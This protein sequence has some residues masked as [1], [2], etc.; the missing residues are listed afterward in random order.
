MILLQIKVCNFILLKEQ[1]IN[2]WNKVNDK[3]QCPPDCGFT[4]DDV[5]SVGVVFGE[6]WPSKQNP[7]S[8][9]PAPRRWDRNGVEGGGAELGSGVEG[10][11]GMEQNGVVEGGTEIMNTD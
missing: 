5:I 4:N 1:M 11:M 8:V 2:K 9:S 6:F 3:N 10:R 7:I